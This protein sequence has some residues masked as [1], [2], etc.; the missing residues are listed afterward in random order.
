MSE[1]KERVDGRTLPE[2]REVRIHSLPEARE[3]R[4]HSLLEEREA[5]IHSQ[6]LGAA[7]DLDTDRIRDHRVVAAK[8]ARITMK[9]IHG[10]MKHKILGR[11]RQPLALP[12]LMD[13][14][15]NSRIP[16]SKRLP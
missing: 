15:G 3:A 5:R 14:V 6:A 12:Q 10:R 4:T 1:G 2:E 11:P 9:R 16:T 13:Q 8:V 7:G